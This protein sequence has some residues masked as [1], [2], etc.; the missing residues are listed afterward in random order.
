[1]SQTR[2]VREREREKETVETTDRDLQRQ[3]DRQM[4]VQSERLKRK[5]YD[6]V[7]LVIERYEEN[8]GKG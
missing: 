6:D 1:M 5:I 8:G 2:G 7:G 4:N 3:R